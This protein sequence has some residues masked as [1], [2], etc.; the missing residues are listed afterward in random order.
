MRR[1]LL[2][3]TV[4][5]GLA[6]LLACASAYALTTEIDKTVVSATASISPRALP[7]RGNAPVD[8]GSITR[9][10]TTDGSQPPTLKQLIFLFDSTARSTPGPADLHAGQ[11]RRHHHRGGAQALCRRDRRQRD[12]QGGRPPPGQAPVAI[13][14]P[15][16]F[17]NAPPGGRQAEPDR[18]CLRDVPVPKTLLVPFSIERINQGRYGF[19]RPDRAA[20]DRRRLRRRDPRRGDVRQDL[21]ARRQDGRLRE[22]PL[23]RR[24]AAGPRHPHLHRRQP[25]PRHLTSPCHVPRLS[26]GRPFSAARL[27]LLLRLERR[28]RAARWSRSTTSSCA[29]TAASSRAPCRA[30]SSRRSTSRATST[31]PPQGGG[32][33]RR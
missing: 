12:R 18:P 25:L 24:P 11:A 29:P 20:A 4:A 1:P 26:K 22:R 8:V 21:D 3:A 7:A 6:G 17:F 15:L 27:A 28:R 16:T 19:Q 9:I 13:S 2:K 5:A 30:S 10:K 14:S 33:P 23:R 31:S 32:K